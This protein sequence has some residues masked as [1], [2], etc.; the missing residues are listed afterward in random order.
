MFDCFFCYPEVE[1]N[2][3]GHQQGTLHP[4]SDVRYSRPVGHASLQYQAYLLWTI[5]D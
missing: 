2:V 4:F 3:M 5:S 1:S